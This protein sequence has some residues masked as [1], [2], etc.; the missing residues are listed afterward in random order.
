MKGKK[1]IQVIVL[2]AFLIVIPLGSWYY[3]QMGFD[4]RKEALD[5]LEDHGPL[6]AFDFNTVDGKIN[7]ADSLEGKMVL[8]HLLNTQNQELT[9]Q[10]GDMINRLTNQFKNTSRLAVVSLGVDPQK[11]DQE[12]LMKFAE[13]Y[14]LKGMPHYYLISP[15]SSG[16]TDVAEQLYFPELDYNNSVYFALADTS[17]TVKNHYK[18]TNEQSVRDM[19]T[20]T[21]MFL[22]R[23]PRRKIIFKRETEK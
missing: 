18:I 22:P 11:D 10:Y 19:I 15:D 20:H 16:I 8:A 2:L 13:E 12:A 9:R 4:Y 17:K 5:Q 7:V 6:P 1:P 23:Q 21:A 14:G 3:L